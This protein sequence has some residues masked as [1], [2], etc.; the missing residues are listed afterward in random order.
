[1][2]FSWMYRM[3]VLEDDDRSSITMPTARARREERHHVERETGDQLIS[4][5]VPMSDTGIEHRRDERR[6]GVAEEHQHD[7]GGEQARRG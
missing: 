2:P 3:D 1:M 4:A 6:R 5:K 7:Q